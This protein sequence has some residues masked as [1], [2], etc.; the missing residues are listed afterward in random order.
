MILKHVT[1][2]TSLIIITAPT[3]NTQ[4]FSYRDLNMIKRAFDKTLKQKL[5]SR[6]AGRRSG[7][8]SHRGHTRSAKIASRTFQGI[9]D[10]MADQWGSLADDHQ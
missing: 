6:C 2:C 5:N 3:F 9:A 4:R 7:Q 1:K 8:R 10:A